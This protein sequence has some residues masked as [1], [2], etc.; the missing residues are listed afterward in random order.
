MS[1]PANIQSQQVDLQEGETR[2]GTWELQEEGDP[3][4]DAVRGAIGSL[5]KDSVSPPRL[6]LLHTPCNARVSCLYDAK[7]KKGAT[8]EFSGSH[9]C[10]IDARF[11][12]HQF[13]LELAVMQGLLTGHGAMMPSRCQRSGRRGCLPFQTPRAAALS[14]RSG[15][16][17]PP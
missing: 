8:L 2:V 14:P 15:T 17:T 4:H 16:C 12:R 10:M 7:L 13:A 5:F 1:R 9:P 3:V 11:W 6:I